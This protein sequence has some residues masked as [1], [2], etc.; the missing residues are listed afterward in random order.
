MANLPNLKRERAELIPASIEERFGELVV[1]AALEECEK[2]IRGAGDNAHPVRVARHVVEQGKQG[3]GNTSS[4]RALERGNSSKCE[5][6]AQG[7]AQA[8]ASAPDAPFIPP[9][10]VREVAPGVHEVIAP[11]R[12]MPVSFGRAEPEEE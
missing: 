7:A 5:R 10:R 6:G 3:S 11:P 9:P 4:A 8:R 1:D 2:E 12:N